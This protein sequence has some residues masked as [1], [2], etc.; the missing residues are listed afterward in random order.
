[1][2]EDPFAFGIEK[3]NS[4]TLYTGTSIPHCMETK[5]NFKNMCPK[6]L[7]AFLLNKE[8]V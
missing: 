4:L 3:K 6:S 5:Q 7:L 1:V 2:V 8:E